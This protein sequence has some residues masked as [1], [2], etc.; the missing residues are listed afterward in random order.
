[1]TIGEYIRKFAADHDDA[2]IGKLKRRHDLEEKEEAI[3]NENRKIN[4]LEPCKLDYRIYTDDKGSEYIFYP[5]TKAIS[6]VTPDG[7]VY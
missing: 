5:K 1:M 3:M 2:V 4:F 7:G 6:G